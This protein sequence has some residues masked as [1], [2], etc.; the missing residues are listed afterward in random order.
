MLR[1]TF[2]IACGVVMCLSVACSTNVENSINPN[3]RGRVSTNV[4]RIE[5][6]NRAGFHDERVRQAMYRVPREK[7]LPQE[8]V[9]KAY[10]DT[11]LPIGFEQTIS[12][13]Y[14]VA[15]MSQEA[16]IARGTKVL[17]IGTGSGYQ[18]AVLVELGARVYSIELLEQLAEQAESRLINLGY[19]DNVRVR[20][21]DGALGWPQEAP[22]DVILITAAA[23]TIPPALIKQ[24]ADGGRMILPLESQDTEEERLVLLTRK[25]NDLVSKD[26]GPVRFVPMK[27]EIRQGQ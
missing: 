13:P 2:C 3:V 25:G 9:E 14:I 17:E 18:S 15:I 24:L 21:G 27:G 19:G 6:L 23:P 10:E 16:Q 11:P 20:H 12:Q 22:F 8:L 7:F 26:L 1:K 4:L 5:G